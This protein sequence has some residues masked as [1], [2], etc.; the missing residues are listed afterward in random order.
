MLS[1]CLIKKI[2]YRL[3]EHVVSRKH[4]TAYDNNKFY[5]RYN[6]VILPSNCSKTFTNVISTRSFTRLYFRI[7]KSDTRRHGTRFKYCGMHSL[8]AF[9]KQYLLIFVLTH[10]IVRLYSVTTG[11]KMLCVTTCSDEVIP[12]HEKHKGNLSIKDNNLWLPHPLYH[13]C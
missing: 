7:I 10:A 13:I 5:S 6:V 9:H 2:I 1:H 8:Q 12:Q 11:C 4:L 3:I